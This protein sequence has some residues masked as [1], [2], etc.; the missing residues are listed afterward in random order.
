MPIGAQLEQ[1]VYSLGQRFADERDRLRDSVAAAVAEL[2]A[3]RA[4]AVLALERAMAGIRNGEAGAPGERGERGETGPAGPPGDKGDPGERG[5]P[6]PP[7]ER[8]DRGEPGEPGTAGLAGEKGD[9]GDPGERGEPGEPGQPGERGERGE[10]G[11]A[12]DKG[13]RGDPGERGAAGDK[14]DPGD[15]GP[16]GEQGEKGDPGER[17]DAG[18]RGPPGEPGQP[19]ERGERGEPG[20]PGERGLDGLNGERGERGEPG[21]DGKFRKPEPWRE[22]VHY[23]G[24]LVTCDGATWIA[25]RDNATRPPGDD[26][27]LVAARGDDGRTG[28]VLGL[29]DPGRA[30]LA[31]DRVSLDGSEWIATTDDPG[32]LPGDG[33]VLGAKAGSK[34]RPGERGAA[35][36]PGAPGQPGV[37]LAG[38]PRIE[39]YQIVWPLTDGKSVR[40]DLRPAFERFNEERGA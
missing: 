6:G 19:G 2:E 5:E 16:I 31:L 34:G 28:R 33:W 12:G 15:I 4:T 20:Q 1:L 7:G 27:I 23:D 30:Y 38:E 37:G 36:P 32:A 13:E 9:R 29:Y 8:G 39:G 14:G 11:A 17:G 3:Q 10:P 25:A 35:G 26:W 40:L 21:A 18:E 24:D 22:G